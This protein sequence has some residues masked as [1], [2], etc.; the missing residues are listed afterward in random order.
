[1]THHII[2]KRG[3][4][5]P[6]YLGLAVAIEHVLRELGGRAELDVVLARI[7]SKYVKGSNGERVVMRLYHHP[8]GELWSPDIEEVLRVLEAAGVVKRRGRVLVME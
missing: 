6:R 4:T 7:W 3:G 5:G 2:G 1:M 8:S